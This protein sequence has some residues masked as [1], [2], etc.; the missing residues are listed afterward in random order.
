MCQTEEDFLL[1]NLVVVCL[2]W[3]YT[4]PAVG[5]DCKKIIVLCWLS[6]DDLQIYCHATW[7]P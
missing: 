7:P 4:F 3:S 1:P 2:L 5:L 6:I